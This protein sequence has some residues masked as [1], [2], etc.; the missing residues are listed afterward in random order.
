M[1]FKKALSILISFAIG[2][3]PVMV[4]AAELSVDGDGGDAYWLHTMSWEK[5]LGDM[6]V[7]K[8][9]KVK[10]SVK[11]KDVAERQVTISDPDQF[12]W[13]KKS[14][15]LSEGKSNTYDYQWILRNPDGEQ[16]P[17]TTDEDAGTE[18]SFEFTAKQEGRY[19]VYVNVDP[20][21][22]DAKSYDYELLE[23]SAFITVKQ[24]Q[25]KVESVTL[26]RTKVIAA[27]N[28][29][30][31]L[32]ATIS[33]QGAKFSKTEWTS[34]DP[35]F[36][37]IKVKN[38]L[39]AEVTVKK[40]TGKSDIKIKITNKDGSTV[41][42]KCTI[43]SGVPVTKVK[44]QSDTNTVLTGKKL[45]LTAKITPKDA[46]KK[47]VVWTSS[48]ES[49]ATVNSNGRVKAKK[50]GTVKITAT[51]KDGSGKKGSIELNIRQAVKSIEF[52]TSPVYIGAGGKLK[53]KP[54][55]L[56]KKAA[57]KKLKWKSSKPKVATVDKNGTVTGVKAGKAVITAT[58]KDGSGTKKDLTVYVGSMKVDKKK[59][60][61]GHSG[62][63]SIKIDLKNDSVVSVR[64]GDESIATIS[65]DSRKNIITVFGENKGNTDITVTS[66]CGI[67]KKID[68]RVTGKTVR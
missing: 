25:I 35:A 40:K 65:F 34:S 68:V 12:K 11:L 6:T 46:T 14:Q 50:A 64:V 32:K 23:S 26:D 61:V 3:A 44:I 5:Q 58:A 42:K 55:V 16:L 9:E 45:Q 39:T 41:S 54:T 28:D 20:H 1:R 27:K 48:D 47:G 17:P 52:E 43:T 33:P 15:Y 49:K 60:T 62:S 18:S 66:R 57:N 8:G 7:T 10:V 37:S 36:A 67:K 21:D 59:V 56:P 38:D 2:F 63:E 22:S 53:L 30:I 29:V 24:P 4:N 51:A 13:E 31:K 19:K